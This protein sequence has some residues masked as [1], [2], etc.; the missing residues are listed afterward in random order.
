MHILLISSP[1]EHKHRFAQVHLQFPLRNNSHTAAHRSFPSC[2]SWI[3]PENLLWPSG[4]LSALQTG[5]CCLSHSN[6]LYLL[7]P[8]ESFQSQ[9]EPI[10]HFT[11]LYSPLVVLE[12]LYSFHWWTQLM[13]SHSGCSSSQV[14]GH[15]W[16]PAAWDESMRR[17]TD[18]QGRVWVSQKSLF[19]SSPHSLCRRQLFFPN[20][21]WNAGVMQLHERLGPYGDTFYYQITLTHFTGSHCLELAY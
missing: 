21:I 12:N 2:V 17:W 8:G 7:L 13:L 16:G 6:S 4:L 14:G 18:G 5:C 3:L 15:H 20:I 10:R 11:G 1:A 9:L 19:S